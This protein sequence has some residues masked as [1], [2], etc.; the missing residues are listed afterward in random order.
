MLLTASFGFA[1]TVWLSSLDLAQ[2]TCG[3]S[4]PKTD[5]GI[6]G[7]P[8][9]IGGT[10]FTI[11]VGT[12][13][14]SKLRVE[15]G[16]KATRFFA[17]VGVDDSAGTRGSVEFLVLGDGKV[18]WRSGPLTGGKPA[19][20]VDANL[21]GVRILTLRATDAGDGTDSDH[22]DWAAAGIEMQG[23]AAMPV[24]LQPYERFAVR[25]KT[26]ATEFQVGDDGRLYQHA[27]G[28]PETTRP[29]RRFDEAYPQW[30]D[31]YIW[32]PAV[33]VTH[34]DGNTSTHLLYQSVTRTNE[35]A[36]REVVRINLRDAAYPFEV[37]LCFRAHINRD[38]VE[39][40]TEIRNHERGAVKLERMA[41][42]SL[43]L[44]PTN[45]YLTHFFRD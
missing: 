18:L 30:G 39:Q 17:K 15:L 5:L 43:L 37:T 41:S 32:E 20:T 25:T 24:A 23:G 27:L 8:L 11:G 1:K 36:G 22:A 9:S 4:V 45:V 16:G 3:W 21:K 44:S 13:A 42:S 35:A 26:F 12:H 40:W 7:T 2:M 6:A 33:Q 19:V 14:E 31:G 34:A 38:L 29:P 28:E 10:Q